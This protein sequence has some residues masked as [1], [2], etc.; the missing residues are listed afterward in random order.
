MADYAMAK[1]A[2]A[3]PPYILEA[4]MTEATTDADHSAGDDIAVVQAPVTAPEN[5]SVTQAA[6]S[7][8]QWR[9]IATKKD[10]TAETTS[11]DT[12]A[13]ADPP[14][15]ES[16]AQAEE[17]ASPGEDPG[18]PGQTEGVPEPAD[19]L[20]PIEPPRSWTKDEKERFQSL[21]RE[22]QAYLAEREQER[23]REFA[24]VKTKPLKSSRALRPRSRRWNRQ[25]RVM[26]LHCRN[27]SP[28]CKASTPANLPTSEP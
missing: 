9:A 26:N 20:P 1:G 24:G 5:L 18:T 3:N 13:A 10:Q 17:A 6:C 7:L 27:C 28:T 23:D 16:T 21:P 14:I 25:G 4:K 11:A 15:T 12:T 19:E 2:M 8:R 22:T